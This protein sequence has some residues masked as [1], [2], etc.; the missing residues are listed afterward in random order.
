[1]DTL[2]KQTQKNPILQ[3]NTAQFRGAQGTGASRV[4]KSSLSRVVVPKLP[5][6]L[7]F[8]IGSLCCDNPQL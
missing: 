5:N 7:I 6:A 8:N 3:R 2:V 1:M 4:R